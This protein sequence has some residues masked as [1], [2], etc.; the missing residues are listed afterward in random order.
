MFK[1]LDHTA[2]FGLRIRARDFAGLVRNATIAL[3]KVWFGK[4]KIPDRRIIQEI[5][6][7]GVDR[8]QVLVK[9]L[10]E[11]IFLIDS[12]KLIPVDVNC[13]LNEADIN[14]NLHCIIV[15]ADMRKSGLTAARPIKAATYHQL[16]IRKVSYGLIADIFFD[17]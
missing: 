11:V 2:D 6:V 9:Y 13:R 7:T 14:V 10:N 4:V 5:K 16:S 15:G 1:I 12:Q 17:I 8:E 3:V